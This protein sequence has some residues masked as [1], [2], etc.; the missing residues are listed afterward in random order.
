DVNKRLAAKCSLISDDDRGLVDKKSFINNA[1]INKEK[2]EQIFKALK[3]LGVI[4]KLNRI[5]KT[6]VD[7]LIGFDSEKIEIERILAEKIDV[8]SGHAINA[9]NLKIENGN[10]DVRLAERTF[11]YELFKAGNQE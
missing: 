7:G 5:Q 9:L 6:K 1:E 2:S 3:T 8:F 10:L 11:E 4:D